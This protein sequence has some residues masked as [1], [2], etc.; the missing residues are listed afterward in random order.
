MIRIVYVERTARTGKHPHHFGRVNLGNRTLQRTKYPGNLV[1]RTSLQR[2]VNAAYHCSV[3]M[4]FCNVLSK[5]VPLLPTIASTWGMSHIS[6]CSSR[7]YQIQAVS[8]SVADLLQKSGF[9]MLSFVKLATIETAYS[10][11]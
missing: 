1:V 5:A 4:F 10:R 2:I 11:A 9:F 3:M 8:T 7:R 6:G